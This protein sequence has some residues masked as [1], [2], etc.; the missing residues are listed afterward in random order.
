MKEQHEL[1]QVNGVG[2]W[3]NYAF[4]AVIFCCWWS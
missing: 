2:I 4:N 3:F 1:M